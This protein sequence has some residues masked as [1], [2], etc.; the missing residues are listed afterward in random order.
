MNKAQK[1]LLIEL[2]KLERNR[3]TLALTDW[4]ITEDEMR[5][6]NQERDLC[7]ST[8]KSLTGGE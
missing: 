8:L 7:T 5:E 2:V 4:N 1:D 6:L 3:L